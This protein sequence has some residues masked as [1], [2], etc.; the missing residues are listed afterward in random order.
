MTQIVTCVVTCVMTGYSEFDGGRPD[1]KCSIVSQLISSYFDQIELFHFNLLMD[2][3]T[4]P[5]PLI[6]T[7]AKYFEIND[8]TWNSDEVQE[9]KLFNSKEFDLGTKPQVT[10]FNPDCPA[11]KKYLKGRASMSA[12]DATEVKLK[13]FSF[14]CLCD[15]SNCLF[16]FVS[17]SC[18]I[19]D[20]AKV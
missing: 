10:V 11:Y 1:P 3:E 15:I 2:S 12:A 17:I 18:L 19:R 13:V 4:G 5:W 7:Y 9:T 14:L 20:Q 6:R 8:N 16:C